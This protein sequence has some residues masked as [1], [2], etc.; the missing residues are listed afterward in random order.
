[1]TNGTH[2]YEKLLVESLLPI[3]Y[4]RPRES[5]F[6]LSKRLLRRPMTKRGCQEVSQGIFTLPGNR[7]PPKMMET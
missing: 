2:L 7:E 6:L 4:C 5:N 3:L 1:M